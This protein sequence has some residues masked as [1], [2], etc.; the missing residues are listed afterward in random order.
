[1]HDIDVILAIGTVWLGL[2]EAKVDFAYAN[3]DLFSIARSMRMIGMRVVKG[4]NH[5]LMPL[6][7]SDEL[8]ALSD[9][10]GEDTEEPLEPTFSAFQ[11][12]E[13]EKHQE[14]FAAAEQAKQNDPGNKNRPPPSLD[15][16]E[17]QNTT[18]LG[19]I[20]HFMLAVAEK[21]IKDGPST[22]KDVATKRALV[23]LRFMDSLPGVLSKG[24][25]RRVARNIVR[26]AGW[27][28][29]IWPRFD[30][31]EEHWVD[32]LRQ[33]GN[34]CGE[35]T[36]LNAWAY[37][38]DIPLATTRD[39]KLGYGSYIEVRRMIT[40]A[41]RG[42]LD[43][44]TI[45]AWMQHSG[46][47]EDEPLSQLQQIQME[48]PDS[49]NNLRNMQTVALNE[50]T[51]NEIVNDIN[52]QEQAASQADATKCS[53][54][55]VPSDGIAP[56]I[57]DGAGCSTLQSKHAAEVTTRTKSPLSSAIQSL[58]TDSPNNNSI[59]SNPTVSTKSTSSKSDSQ[60]PYRNWKE[61]LVNRRADMRLFKRT[62]LNPLKTPSHIRSHS[63]LADYD[64]V[65]GIAPIWE[66]LKRL[67]RADFDFTY[68]GMDV[69]SPSEQ[70]E[71]VGAVGGR[72]RFIMPLFIWD[73]DS[74]ALENPRRGSPGSSGI[75]HLLLCVAELINDEPMTVRCE[76]M[77]S[78]PGS[79][80]AEDIVAK[81]KR[82]IENSRWLDTGGFTPPIVYQFSIRFVPH[83]VG[84][85]TCGLHVILNAW[86]YMLGIPIYPKSYRRGR[87]AEDQFDKA[88]EEFLESGL[89]LVN[90]A[91]AGLMDSE[92]IQAFFNVHGYCDE[93]R[94]GDPARAVVKVNAIGMNQEKL[95]LT[96][97]QR[98]I[99]PARS[100]GDQFNE[101]HIDYLK[102][103]NM[104]EDQAWRALLMCGGNVD[105]A[106]SWHFGSSPVGEMERPESALS[107]K[108]PE[109]LDRR[110]ISSRESP[111][112]EPTS[113]TITST[114]PPSKTITS[115]E[116]PS[117]T[118]TS[119][120]SPS[121]KSPSKKSPSRKSSSRESSSKKS[122]SKKSP[123]RKSPSRKSSSRKSPSKNSTSKN[124][125]SRKSPSKKS[126]SK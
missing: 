11:R 25:I 59:S 91:L 107:P 77:D 116:S 67:N 84:M 113:K 88:D 123:P 22:T 47:A 62:S 64:V 80:P 86:A 14:N 106:M 87:T 66:G 40:L 95:R 27:L 21:V 76:I 60:L 65:L 24:Q 115:R 2:M 81:I 20:G 32:V 55:S 7:F 56:V 6:L 75:G 110:G 15:D 117:Q 44:L 100:R 43:S 37:M 112:R 16:Q 50:N 8:G 78:S 79:A 103:Q 98:R 68:A 93:Q 118:I 125:T 19:G 54:L 94:F 104:S 58:D 48:H 4:T 53:A 119:R 34:R 114:E 23:R 33:S 13:A 35:H 71:M 89:E 124:S 70:D 49:P 38:L 1:M 72:S 108:T 30:V 26:N 105:R 121:R 12:G 17:V 69:F 90:L 63:R 51:F 92:I 3:S 42:Q 111:S 18:H 9:E 41:L 46:Y 101:A 10:P 61:F 28:G 45:R 97:N 82:I 126:L 74:E 5:F 36:V 85:H 52:L 96:L 39:R 29:D 73:E 57:P 109:T 102:G 31:S 120:K 83:Q 122:P 99:A